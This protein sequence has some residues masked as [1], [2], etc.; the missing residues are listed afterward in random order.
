M[1]QKDLILIVIIIAVSTIVSFVLSGMLISP[2]SSRQQDVEKVEAITTEFPLPDKRFFNK[3][4]N[5]PTKLIQIGD[6]TKP[7][8]FNGQSQ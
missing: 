1:K 8:P 6:S 2:P 3:D 7:V 4:S 5:N